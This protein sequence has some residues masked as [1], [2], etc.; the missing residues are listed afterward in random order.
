MKRI[1]KSKR[2]TLI[3]VLCSF[4]LCCATLGALPI[5]SASAASETITVIDENFNKTNSEDGWLENSFE[6]HREKYSLQYGN[7]GFGGGLVPTKYKVDKSCT[8]SYKVS[9]HGSG[10]HSG[11]GLEWVGFQVGLENLSMTTSQAGAMF[12]SYHNGHTGIMDHEDGSKPNLTNDS[13]VANKTFPDG[14]CAYGRDGGTACVEIKLT[15]RDPNAENGTDV[16]GRVLYDVEYRVWKDGRTKPTSALTWNNKGV[17]ADGYVA[18]GGIIYSSSFLRIYDFQ[19]KEGE[20]VAFDAEFSKDSENQIGDRTA[21]WCARDIPLADCVISADSY[22]DTKDVATGVL[23]SETKLTVDPYVNKQFDLSFDVDCEELPVGASF[24]VGFGLSA[25]SKNP[26]ELN[27]IG[28]KGD[29]DGKWKFVMTYGGKDRASSSIFDNYPV[30]VEKL[31][32]AGDYA[33]NVTVT[34]GGQS[35]TFKNI[36]FEGNFALATLGSVASNAKFDNVTLSVTSRKQISGVVEDRAIDFTGVKKIEDGTSSYEVSYID[37]TKWYSGTN[38]HLSRDGKKCVQFASANDTS[39]F[40]PRTRYSDFI[41]RFSVTASQN[42]NLVPDGAAV[43]LSFGR[44]SFLTNNTSAAGLFFEKTS[45]GMQL[46]IYNASSEQA[47]NGIIDVSDMDIWS[48]NDVAKQPVTYNVMVVV[49]SGNAEIYFAP[50]DAP[51]SEMQILRATLT[52]FD[53]YGFVAVAGRGSSAFKLNNMSVINLERDKS[54][55]TSMESAV[56]R[57]DFS[58]AS[59]YNVSGETKLDDLGATL[60]SEAS[61]STKETFK[62]FLLYTDVA[63]ENGAVEIS[64]GAS[65]SITFNANGKIETALNKIS[66]DGEFDYSDFVNGATIYMQAIG[67]SITIGVTARVSPEEFLYCP[68]AVYACDNSIGEIKISSQGKTTVGYI[69][70]YSLS[71]TIKIEPDDWEEGDGDY[72]VKPAPSGENTGNDVISSQSGCYGALTGNSFWIVSVMLVFALILVIRS[73]KTFVGGEKN[74]RK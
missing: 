30:G 45:D 59:Q 49:R 65:N 54:N 34:F 20:E 26:D 37:S 33:G 52:D 35:Y 40:G 63:T 66:G 39:A 23:L 2:K 60:V 55:S 68:I 67:N 43:G 73:E 74:E 17:A 50:S 24:G 44:R 28:V 12:V 3:A 62:D 13:L 15:R 46:R 64:F 4:V 47:H 14:I 57:I 38:V 5:F 27:Y 53:G 25:L 72:P 61:V 36:D 31:N 16:A 19:I 41:C 11:L 18:F 7:S 58:D 21:A 29:A 42:R 22:V 71:S 56:A 48:S 69:N 70:V 1:A 32:F 6:I 10:N 8:I 51:A 9:I